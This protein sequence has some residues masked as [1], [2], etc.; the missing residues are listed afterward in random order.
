MADDKLKK[1]NICGT[2]ESTGKLITYRHK[3]KDEFCC[4]RCLP[5]LIHG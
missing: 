4:T 3:G 1:C 2:D 5:M